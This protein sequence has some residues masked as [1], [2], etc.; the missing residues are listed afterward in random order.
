[1]D[2][3]LRLFQKI[4]ALGFIVFGIIAFLIIYSQEFKLSANASTNLKNIAGKAVWLTVSFVIVKVFSSANFSRSNGKKTNWPA[5]IMMLVAGFFLSVV[6]LKF[7][8]R[9]PDIDYEYNSVF[10]W[11]LTLSVAL[12]FLAVWILLLRKTVKSIKED[13]KLSDNERIKAEIAKV[14][15]QQEQYEDGNYTPPKTTAS[16]ANF[17]I[18]SGD[19]DIA[20]LPD[21]ESAD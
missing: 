20:E 10:W 6:L 14:K 19:F 11:I 4:S 5:L 8:N 3:K 2:K 7:T 15:A 12:I 16:H 9:L 17:D 21:D 1:M 13:K 18:Y